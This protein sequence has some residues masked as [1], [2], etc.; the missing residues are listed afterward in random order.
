VHY[1]AHKMQDEVQSLRREV[2]RQE[3]QLGLSSFSK[4]SCGLVSA[5]AKGG[6]TYLG[7]SSVRSTLYCT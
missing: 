1:T 2:F 4:V 6:W 3:S 5:F 7:V